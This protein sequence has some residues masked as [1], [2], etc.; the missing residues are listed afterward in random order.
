MPSGRRYKPGVVPVTSLSRRR[1]I[2]AM[3]RRRL[4][5]ENTEQ[6][7]EYACAVHE[8]YQKAVVIGLLTRSNTVLAAALQFHQTT[9]QQLLEQLTH[10]PRP[11]LVCGDHDRIPFDNFS[12]SSFALRFRLSS[13]EVLLHVAEC[14][15][16]PEQIGKH[17]YV[18]SREDALGLCFARLA[19][20]LRLHDLATSI[21][22]RWSGGKMSSILSA[23]IDAIL[24]VWNSRIQLDRRVFLQ[25]N[26][27][28][29][30]EF[31][32]ALCEAGAPIDTCVGFIDGTTVGIN[33]PGGPT[34]N[35]R[36][37]YSGH[38]RYHCLRYQALTT[39]DG[40]IVSFFG[41]VG[42]TF[43]LRVP[44]YLL[45]PRIHRHSWLFWHHPVGASND[46][47]MTNL[48][49]IE[50]VLSS[51]IT[52]PGANP[53]LYIYG[54]KAYEGSPAIVAPS[55]LSASP[56]ADDQM[57]K[58]RVSVENVFGSMKGEPA[59]TLM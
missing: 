50:E 11:S 9:M 52:R 33:R 47:T 17:G 53:R 12:P 45:M 18:A 34:D 43:I 51:S 29:L 37:V 36:V 48:S 42:G 7:E 56:G 55:Q 49:Q 3:T 16:L 31:G 26:H 23:T 40:M 6:T 14:L 8:M 57:K 21:G 46:R 59:A 54:D 13:K 38:K 5:R 1:N 32:A 15:R 28:R 27:E 22:L 10:V 4:V 39:P 20:P 2:P 41:P 19:T 58:C 30:L 35:Q 25:S 44:P 24:D